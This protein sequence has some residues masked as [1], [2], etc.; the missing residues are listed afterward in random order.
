MEA[1]V[2]KFS[3]P[4]DFGG[5]KAP[6]DFYIGEPAQGRHPLQYQSAWL[7]EYRGGTVPKEVMENFAKILTLALENG[8]SF[9]ELCA[10][11][12]EANQL[13]EAE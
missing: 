4:C 13:K 11:A 2:K 12:I 9:E 5:V 8:V 6:F 10:Y 1:N 7:A 3:V